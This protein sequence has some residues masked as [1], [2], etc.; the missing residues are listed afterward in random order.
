MDALCLEVEHFLVRSVHATCRATEAAR[1]RST[2]ARRLGSESNEI[3]GGAVAQSSPKVEHR[4]PV[5]DGG[6]SWQPQRRT[7]RA[8]AA[9]QVL[10]L[11]LDC[12]LG[13]RLVRRAG[14]TARRVPLFN[15]RHLVPGEPV[16]LGVGELAV[17]DRAV[18]APA[19][20]K[21][22]RMQVRASI[23]YARCSLLAAHCGRARAGEL[24]TWSWLGVAN[25]GHSRG[26]AVPAPIRLWGLR[27]D[28]GSPRPDRQRRQRRSAGRGRRQCHLEAGRDQRDQRDHAQHDAQPARRLF[29]LFHYGCSQRG[30]D[31]VRARSR[32]QGQPEPAGL[33]E[34]F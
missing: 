29:Q 2:G 12:A 27:D 32:T 31:R 19:R 25:T 16:H 23:R 5:Q 9:E 34:E 10:R 11:V 1:Q 14:G 15:R 20:S 17:L 22:I 26:D 4:V 18:E 33:M 8:D 21:T 7:L 3:R 30:A 28:G 13:A 6:W 24:E